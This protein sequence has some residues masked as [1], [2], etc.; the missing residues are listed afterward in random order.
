MLSLD[1]ITHCH[2]WFSILSLAI[3]YAINIG[4][5][6]AI[7]LTLPLR[8]CITLSFHW[9]CRCHWLMVTMRLHGCHAGWATGLLLLA[10]GWYYWYILLLPWWIITH[11]HYC[12]SYV[13][14]HTWCHWCIVYYAVISLFRGLSFFFLM[15]FIIYAAFRASLMPL[16]CHDCWVAAVTLSHCHYWIIMIADITLIAI[17]GYCHI[18]YYRHCRCCRHWYAYYAILDYCHWLITLLPDITFIYLRPLFA[19]ITTCHFINIGHWPLITYY[20]ITFSHA[21]TT[22]FGFFT[23]IIIIIAAIIFFSFFFFADAI[24]TISHYD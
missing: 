1:I 10:D 5:I 12:I 22:F 3:Y 2:C 23:L 15:L 8:Y 16:R 7:I 9:Y 24:I 6:I 4:F 11:C 19:L 17:S 13:I 20:A 21:I 14:T 18:Q